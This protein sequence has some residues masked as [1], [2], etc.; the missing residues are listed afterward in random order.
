MIKKCEKKTEKQGESES[1]R[2]KM[3]QHDIASVKLIINFFSYEHK[4]QFC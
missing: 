4:I 2:E 1:M 3:K